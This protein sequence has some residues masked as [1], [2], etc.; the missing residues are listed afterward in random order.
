MAVALV[1]WFAFRGTP[2]DIINS[3]P[4][5]FQA[6]AIDAFFFSVGD[7]NRRAGT[8]DLRGLTFRDEFQTPTRCAILEDSGSVRID[9][10]SFIEGALGTRI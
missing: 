4:T 2:S 1:F 9:N 6:K 10:P 3:H 5:E 7:E 8:R